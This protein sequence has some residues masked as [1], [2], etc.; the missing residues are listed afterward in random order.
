MRLIYE[1]TDITDAVSVKAASAFDN[2]G[3]RADSLG[4]LLLN[5]G[6]WYRWG[7]KSGDRIEIQDS[8]YT[9]GEMY[10]DDIIPRDGDFLVC[11]CSMPA[12]ARERRWASYE[13]V[14]LF[15]LINMVASELGMEAALYGVDGGAK[16]AYMERRDES[17][18]RFLQRVL[19]L[20]GATLKC[21][22]RKLLGIGIEWAQRQEA[23]RALTVGSDTPGVVHTNEI[24]RAY[25]RCVIKTP[26]GTGT[27]MQQGAGGGTLFLNNEPVASSAQ[28]ARWARGKLLSENRSRERLTWDF[29][30]DPAMTALARVDLEGQSALSGEW[31]VESVVHDFIE[32]TSSCGLFRCVNGIS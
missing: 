30:F 19:E 12:L 3:G 16:Y 1:G 25:E 20:E 31:L 14:T 21:A 23:V 22:G 7:P 29:A 9:T 24:G 4:V 13:R 32:R 11:G 10:V 6:D 2:A 17:A 18:P 5:A 27:A 26:L 8:G 15:E 28:A